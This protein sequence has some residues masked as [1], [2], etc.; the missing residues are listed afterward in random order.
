MS[1]TG[2]QDDN[3]SRSASYNIDGK[4][5][6]FQYTGDKKPSASSIMSTFK[7][8]HPQSAARKDPLPGKTPAILTKLAGK[9]L[10]NK[11]TNYSSYPPD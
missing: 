6:D 3:K 4:S 11:K 2:S 8:H 7:A 1:T 9:T 5:Y 10:K